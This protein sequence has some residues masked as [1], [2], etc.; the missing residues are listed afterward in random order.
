MKENLPF[1]R[2][3]KRSPDCTVSRGCT[4]CVQKPECFQTLESHLLETAKLAKIFG[5]NL[6]FGQLSY[7]SGLLHDAGKATEEW[8]Q[9]LFD[10]IMGEKAVKKQDHSSIGALLSDLYIEKLTLPKIIIQ[11]AVMYHHGSGLPDFLSLDGTTPFS[12]RLNKKSNAIDIF[13]IESRLP[14][15]TAGEI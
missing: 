10:S 3:Y 4:V 14:I 9:Y 12:D 6:G 11:A 1:A 15:V 7:L 5:N 13:K 2:F 8:Q